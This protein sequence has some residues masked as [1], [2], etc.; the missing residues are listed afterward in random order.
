LK[1]CRIC[2]IFLKTANEKDRSELFFHFVNY[3]TDS[4]HDIC[5]S[6]GYYFDVINPTLENIHGLN[7]VDLLS[8][9]HDKM[10]TTFKTFGI[11]ILNFL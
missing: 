4:I 9:V 2:M 11:D 7:E 5:R 1:T 3:F 10:H 8:Q 6:N